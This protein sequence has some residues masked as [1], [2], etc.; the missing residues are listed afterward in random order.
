MSH[1]LELLG[2]LHYLVVLEHVDDAHQVRVQGIATVHSRNR[3][4]TEF[5]LTRAQEELYWIR[6]DANRPPSVLLL[7]LRLHLDVLDE[8]LTFFVREDQAFV[9]EKHNVGGNLH[10]DGVRLLLLANDLALIEKLVHDQFLLVKHNSTDE[11]H[12]RQEDDEEEDE[13]VFAF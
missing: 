3:R 7:R 12:Q 1:E 5:E 6:V 8:R 11:D 2:Q 13:H 9:V 10:Q 4:N